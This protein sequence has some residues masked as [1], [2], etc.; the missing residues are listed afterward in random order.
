[1]EELM[2]VNVY[3]TYKSAFNIL[4]LQDGA[5]TSHHIILEN[6][7]ADTKRSIHGEVWEW[8]FSD[9]HHIDVSFNGQRIIILSYNFFAR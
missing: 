9:D 1:M 3:M 2:I 6:I 7:G 5:K 4:R 8:I